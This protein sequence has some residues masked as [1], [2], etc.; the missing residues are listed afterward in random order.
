[1]TLDSFMEYTRAFHDD[2]T[3]VFFN[4]DKNQPRVLSILD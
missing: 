3:M 2:D 4:P 1:M